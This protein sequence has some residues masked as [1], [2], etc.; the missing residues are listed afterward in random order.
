MNTISFTVV[1]PACNAANFLERAVRSVTEQRYPR[2]RVVIV[3]D[4]STDATGDVAA[5]L[6][7]ENPYIYVIE[8]ENSG[9]LLSRTRA[10][11]YAQKHF[12][13]ENNYF[14]FL[15]ADDVYLP[16]SL[17]R[18][19]A[20]LTEHGCDLLLYA[21]EQTDE[22]TGKT[23]PFGGS[24]SGEPASKAAL[25]Q[26][27]FFDYRYNPLWRKA[28]S[29]RLI[30]D[31]DF[32]PYGHLRNAEDLVQSLDYYRAAAR[33]CFSDECFYRYYI[34]SASVTHSLTLSKYPL[35]STARRLTWELL[36]EEQV[37]TQSQTDAYA[38]FLLRLL[39]NKIEAICLFDAPSAEK[40]AAYETLRQ[41]GFYRQLLTMAKRRDRVLTLFE[42]GKYAAMERAL[43]LS[44]VAG[45][46][47]RRIQPDR[48]NR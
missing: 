39:K 23:R 2:C 32:T 17:A 20:L 11:R 3:N 48:K 21:A 5:A 29:A 10:I 31:R 46:V 24:F 15:D 14:L 4:G 19:A 13:D 38:A 28:V 25:Y 40:A 36:A 35:D 42:Q 16:G 34:N 41:D 30:A 26:T 33:V 18:I 12:A 27:V 45:A 1:V 9:Q 43:R 47:R 8:Q 44:R 22:V 7:A 6:A 37:W